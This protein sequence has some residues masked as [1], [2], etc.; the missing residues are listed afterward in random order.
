MSSFTHPSLT[1]VIS[2]TCPLFF[3]MHTISLPPMRPLYTLLSCLFAPAL[4]YKVI[5]KIILK[6]LRIL[7]GSCLKYQSVF[8]KIF[9]PLQIK[10]KSQSLY[11]ELDSFLQHEN[12]KLSKNMYLFKRMCSLTTK[13]LLTAA[14]MTVT[15]DTCSAP[16]L[17]LSCYFRK[18]KGTF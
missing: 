14:K 4:L 3:A 7:P 12:H 15:H 16:P 2:N 17:W 13:T 11:L 18:P 8:L 6:W 10:R 9:M 1:A 5:Q